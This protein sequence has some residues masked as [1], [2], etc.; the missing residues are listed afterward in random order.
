MRLVGIQNALLESNHFDSPVRA[1]V[2]AKPKDE[3]DRQ[4]IVL[5]NSRGVSVKDNTLHD[6]ENHTQADTVSG[7]R[8][9]GNEATKELTLDEENLPDAPAR[10]SPR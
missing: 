5:K 6:P 2:I 1:S 8:L 3:T 7:S 4:A 9:L 10:K